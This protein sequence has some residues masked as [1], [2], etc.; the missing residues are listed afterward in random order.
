MNKIYFNWEKIKKMTFE[1]WVEEFRLFL[2][3]ATGVIL[4]IVLALTGIGN[5]ANWIANGF[6]LIYDVA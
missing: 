4:Q 5:I 3:G 1:A 6:L 2:N